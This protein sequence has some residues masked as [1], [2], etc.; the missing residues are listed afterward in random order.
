MFPLIIGGTG[1]S[2]MNNTINVDVSST[3]LTIGAYFDTLNDSVFSGNVIRIDNDMNATKHM[4]VYLYN[5]NRN[6]ISGNNINMVNGSSLDIGM[7]WYSGS[8][9]NTGGDN[10]TYNTGVSIDDNG[11]LNDVTAKDI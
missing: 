7:K 4:G 5:S 2:V 11:S 9:N 1:L 3:E 8:D 10:I 6:I